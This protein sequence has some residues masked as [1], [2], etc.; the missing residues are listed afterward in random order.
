MPP[1]QAL[2]PAA[3]LVV[4][5]NDHLV[6]AGGRRRRLDAVEKGPRGFPVGGRRRHALDVHHQHDVASHAPVGPLV[7]SRQPAQQPDEQRQGVSLV[8]AE[9]EKVSAVEVG[10]RVDAGVAVAVDDAAGRQG[11]AA[12][13]GEEGLA[14]GDT[15]GGVVEHEGRAV[16]GGNPRGDRVGAQGPFR[17]PVGKRAGTAAAVQDDADEPFPGRHLRVL[18]EPPHVLDAAEAGA[19]DLLF[20][21][22]LEQ[23]PHAPAGG[24][25]PVPVAA[26]DDQAG[27]RLPDDRRLGVGIELAV[28]NRLQVPRQVEDPVGVV[29]GEVGVHEH[30]GDDVGDVPRRG[31]GR[32][33]AADE[34]VQPGRRQSFRGRHPLRSVRCEAIISSRGAPLPN[35]AA[36]QHIKAV[37]LGS[38]WVVE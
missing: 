30:F 2:D 27:R 4:A 5:R 38:G 35:H 6:E 13:A 9:A 34:G 29:A 1:D 24:V 19:A 36:G 23:P 17:A 26:V 21:G 16:R 32:Q 20:R 28:G 25:M 15:A 12:A 14:D 10:F 31:R 18:P 11:P 8:A 7:P 37:R 3:V 33:Q 22:L